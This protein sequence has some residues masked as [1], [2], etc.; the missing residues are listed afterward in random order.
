MD[1]ILKQSGYEEYQRVLELYAALDRSLASWLALQACEHNDD[2]IAEAGKDFL[3]KL[4]PEQ[5]HT[6]EPGEEL[7]RT[8]PALL[9]ALKEPEGNA[10]SSVEFVQ[11]Y[12]QFRFDGPVLTSYSRPVIHMGS[13]V[14]KWAEP[15]YGDLFLTMV[16]SRV[17][18]T[19][20]EHEKVILEL[21]S[22]I[23][24]SISLKNEDY[25]G[26]E[27]LELRFP[28]NGAWIVA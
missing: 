9:E 2:E 23:R 14:I 17:A 8:L 6:P 11:D 26:P 25:L 16:G 20:L 12:I 13:R 22:G 5:G 28:D 18:R 19:G 24:I 7:P 21:E 4:G 3:N 15:G 10:L 1:P 27:A